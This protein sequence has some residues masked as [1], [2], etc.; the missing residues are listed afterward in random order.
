MLVNNNE[1]LERFLKYVK[2]WTTSDSEVA[3]KGKC[4][5][6]TRQFDLAEILEEEMKQL[7]LK[8]VKITDT[9][10]I[11]GYLPA[12][13]GFEDKDSILLMSHIDT[14]EDVSGENIHPLVWKEYVDDKLILPNG[15]F[16]EGRELKEA[17]ANKE[18]IITSDGTTL[19]GAD[20]KA[21]IAAIIT[22]IDIL[23]K[24][25]E[26]KHPKIE[27]MFS[28]DEETG[29]SMDHVPLDMIKSK[30]AYTVDG[31]H[32][33]ELEIECFNAWKSEITFTGNAIH[34]G[35][36]RPNLVNAVTMAARFVTNLPL[37]EAPETTDGY[38]G[39]YAPMGIE[40]SME[41]AKVTVFLRDFNA[42]EMEYRK[43]L[44]E[45][46]ANSTALSF[47]GKAQVEHKFQYANMKGKMDENPR[48]VI[49]LIN[50]YKKADV[51]PRIVPI[52][53][54]TD[55][56]RLTEMGIP[57][58]NI[59][60]GGHNYHSRKEW[61]SLQQMSKAAEVLVNLCAEE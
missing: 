25:P 27:V 8:D 50:A 34:T 2:I 17:I 46:L 40:G 51:Q 54:G 30:S 47:H 41:S 39:F 24:H 59:F 4:P 36:G 44:I 3:D 35:S 22:A 31:G 37:Q 53:G 60:T 29:H 23:N 43:K 45:I 38:Q 20:D 16:I 7:G 49:R 5:S 48:V 26:I 28:P 14:A 21:G 58:P 61:C 57:T 12:S 52:R 10:F 6:T 11:Y 13:E 42:E 19:L 18:T 32:I 33:G 9:C 15:L 55:G 1:L 56:S